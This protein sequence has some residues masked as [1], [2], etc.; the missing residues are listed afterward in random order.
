LEVLPLNGFRRYRP[1]SLYIWGYTVSGLVAPEDKT[2]SLI[3][4]CARKISGITDLFKP[5]DP[6]VKEGEE[7]QPEKKPQQKESAISEAILPEQ[8]RRKSEKKNN[9]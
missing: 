2:P 3:K 8:W 1:Q 7:P 4:T 6:E 5:S 9:S